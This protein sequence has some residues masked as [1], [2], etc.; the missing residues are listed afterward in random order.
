M[1]QPPP[2]E[3]GSSP[4][5]P[6]QAEA[7]SHSEEARGAG[8]IDC[9][10]R[11]FNSKILSGKSRCQLSNPAGEDE[12]RFA[13]RFGKFRQFQPRSAEP[14]TVALQE[15]MVYVAGRCADTDAELGWR[16]ARV[17]DAR[18]AVCLAGRL[19]KEPYCFSAVLNFPPCGQVLKIA[20]FGLC[21]HAAGVSACVK[22]AD[23]LDSAPA[24]QQPAPAALHFGAQRVDQ[25]HSRNNYTIHV[26]L[27]RPGPG[28]R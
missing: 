3:H 1:P 9:A 14:W 10:R 26:Y 28:S 2:G 11:P 22:S 16:Q 7:P 6:Y 12:F 17:A 24:V 18:V 4:P 13:D 27:K 8:G 21:R 25:A 19:K 20:R 15:T 5:R 23:S